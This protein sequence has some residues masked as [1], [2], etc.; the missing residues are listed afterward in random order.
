MVQSD[1]PFG[2]E[3]I[4]MRI[5]IELMR[6]ELLKVAPFMWWGVEAEETGGCRLRVVASRDGHTMRFH[7]PAMWDIYDRRQW[8]RQALIMAGRFEQHMEAACVKS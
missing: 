3:T 6:N 1:Q 4:P 2:A 5:K 7:I 8:H